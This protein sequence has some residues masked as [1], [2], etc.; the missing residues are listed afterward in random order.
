[1][2]PGSLVELSILR[3]RVSEAHSAYMNAPLGDS[4]RE[5][6]QLKDARREY[7][8]KCVAFVEGLMD[9]ASKE[10]KDDDFIINEFGWE[11]W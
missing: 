3:N 1:M 2:N 7:A 10:R 9:N 6:Q 5:Y 8:D 4:Y 11:R